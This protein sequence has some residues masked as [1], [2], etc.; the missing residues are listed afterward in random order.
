MF[1]EFDVLH[2][3]TYRGYNLGQSAPDVTVENNLSRVI[4]AISHGL[5][6]STSRAMTVSAL[7]FREFIL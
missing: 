5:T 2:Y 4:T 7:T 3:R 6:S 1:L